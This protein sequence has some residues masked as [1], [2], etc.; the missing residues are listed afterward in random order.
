M[1][2]VRKDNARSV[3]RRIKVNGFKC[4]LNIFVTGVEGVIRRVNGGSQGE[5]EYCLLSAEAGPQHR[6]LAMGSPCTQL[7][8]RKNEVV[9]D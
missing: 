1:Y 9:S 4:K 3:D 6:S 2:L 8:S 7:T 5:K